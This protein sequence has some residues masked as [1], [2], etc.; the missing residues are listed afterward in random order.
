MRIAFGTSAPR[1]AS[2]VWTAPGAI[3]IGEVEVAAGGSIWYGAVIRADGAHVTIGRHTNVQDS[4]VIHADPGLPV[5]I[6][7]R[8]SIG[9]GALLHGCT[10]DDDVLVGMGANILNGA[11]IGS[12]SL[13][14][15]GA[16]VL[17]GTDVPADSL[18]AGVPA[19]VRRATTA[20]ERAHIAANAQNYVV[21]AAKHAAATVGP[22]L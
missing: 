11:R 21:L 19:K 6:G 18:V 9:H 1:L 4:T 20:A 5:V 8:V 3:L 7:D 13:I 15:A 16:V 17:E 14:A 12:G 10:V 2:S 22:E